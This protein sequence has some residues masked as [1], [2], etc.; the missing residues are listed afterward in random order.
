MPHSISPSSA[1]NDDAMPD[2]PPVETSTE[3]NVKLEDMFND[4]DD[5]DEFPAS[6]D[7]KMDSPV[8]EE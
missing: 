6:G 3:T 4:D 1:Q 5:D 2:A 8:K 7:V